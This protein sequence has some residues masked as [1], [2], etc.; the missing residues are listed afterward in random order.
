[1]PP[2]FTHDIQRILLENNT[3]NSNINIV[4]GTITLYGSTI[5]SKIQLIIQSS[6][7]KSNNTTSSA[8]H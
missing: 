1:M 6:K 5:P 2:K 8:N 3:K 7:V 4:Y